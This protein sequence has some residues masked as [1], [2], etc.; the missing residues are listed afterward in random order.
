MKKKSKN[1]VL[2]VFVGLAILLIISTRFRSKLQSF[3]NGS[4]SPATSRLSELGNNIRSD[5]SFIINIRNLKRQND[6]LTQKL[7]DLQVD[8]SQMEE[9]KNENNL[10]KKEL[11]FVSNDGEDTLVPAKITQRD[12][13]TYL[14]YIVI[15]KG[16]DHDIKVGMAVV[17]SGT[18]VGAISK[19]D[20]STA[21]VTLIT[22]RDSIVQAMLQDSRAKG[23]LRGG[24]SGLYIDNIVRDTVYKEGENVVTSGL[25]GDIKQGIL[26]GK[27]GKLQSASSGIFKTIDVEPIVSI[28]DL[29]LVFVQ[30]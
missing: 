5:F 22:S 9:L 24:I 28:S 11:G 6:D 23:I 21:T 17:A 10:L 16:A 30:K 19:V 26:I 2:I 29:E 7:V 15:D 20:R 3:A 12:P 18:L 4:S 27:T 8:K 13:A 1:I 14:D 25:G